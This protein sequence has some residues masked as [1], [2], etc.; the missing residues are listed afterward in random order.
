MTDP[1]SLEANRQKC[2]LLWLVSGSWWI[3]RRVGRYNS[4]DRAVTVAGIPVSRRNERRYACA[5]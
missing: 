1:S 4:R 2:L 5:T 3:A